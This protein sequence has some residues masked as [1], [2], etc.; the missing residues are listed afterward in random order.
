MAKAD[1]CA[2]ALYSV[3]FEPAKRSYGD[4]DA[5]TIKLEY[6]GIAFYGFIHVFV[7]SVIGLAAKKRLLTRPG[8]PAM[9]MMR[10]NWTQAIKKVK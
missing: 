10:E 7:M 6:S 3:V 1:S 5:A 2:A 8:G 9:A 4:A